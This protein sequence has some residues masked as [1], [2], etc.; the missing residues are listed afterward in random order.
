[1]KNVPVVQAAL[2]APGIMQSW[3]RALRDFILEAPPLYLGAGAIVA[4]DGLGNLHVFVPL[5][6][7]LSVTAAA[8]ALFLLRRAALGIAVAVLGIIAAATLPVRDLLVPEFTTRTVTQFTDGAFIKLE[9]RLVRAPEREENGRTYLYVSAKRAALSQS[10]LAPVSGL[11]RV[12]VIGAEA[13]RIGDQI[14]VSGRIRIPRNDGDEGEFDYRSWLMRQGIA[15]TIFTAKSQRGSLRPVTVNGHRDIF[16]TSQVEEIR[17]HIARF[18]DASVSYPGNAE[19]RALLI[20]DRGGI[21]QALRQPF[22]LTGMA[23]MLVISGLHLGLVA[24]AAFFLA[25]LLISFFSGLMA[26][27]YASKIGAMV[28]AGAV[29]GYATIAGG[30]VSTIRALVMVLAYAL[31]LLIDRSRELLAS[32]A[33]AALVI[34]FMLPGSTADIGFQLSFASVLVILLGMRR[35]AAWWRWHYANPL[36]ALTERSRF[37]RAAEW[38]CGY[39]AVSFWAMLGTAPLTAFHFNQFSTVGLVANAVVVPIM[40]VG[41]VVCGLWAAAASFIYLPLARS[42]LVLAAKFA[43]IGTFLARW[44]ASWPLAWVRTFTP[45]GLEITIAYGFILLWLTAPLAGSHVLHTMRTREPIG[46]SSAP[47]GRLG[48]EDLADAARLWRGAISALLLGALVLDA[49]LWTYRRYLNPALRVTFLSV[50]EGDAAIVRFPGPRVMLIDG[51]GAFYGSFD[52][53]ERIVAPYLWSQKIMRVDYI[54][55]SHPD[56]DHFGGLTFIVRNFA[57]SE[58]WTA[59]AAS[60]DVGFGELMDA[61]KA[62]GA[63]RRLCDSASPPMTIAGVRVRC[64]GPLHNVHNLTHNNSS[65]VLRIS[66]RDESFLFTGDIEAKGERQLLALP[67]E[68]RATVLKVP[69]HGSRTSSTAAFI[70]AVHPEI[71]V[72]SLGYL[73]QFHFPAPE[74]IARYQTD[75]VR[76]LRTDQD[77]EVTVEAAD[78]SVRVCTFRHGLIPLAQREQ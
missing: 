65:M 63:R 26:L 21:D 51:G 34:C 43:G 5:S 47:P 20:G 32:L 11:V 58:F 69:H 67:A 29:L 19:L 28:A 72:V 60:Q 18:I 14:S 55:L 64:V 30:H 77:G 76:V 40:G 46:Q 49:A 35:F 48:A 50:G 2:A 25:R 74:V 9:G 54:A 45:T 4:G 73:N 37:A 12:T 24:A 59:G 75:G 78:N 16:P 44:F 15:A 22:A 3:K 13:F 33:L 27:G 66:Q 71:A 7:G 62:S 52:P 39:F 68:L 57:P 36:S 42:M 10:S 61:V 23:H 31:A 53:G 6:V 8:T 56:R 38:I 70:E 17:D 1:V 41:T